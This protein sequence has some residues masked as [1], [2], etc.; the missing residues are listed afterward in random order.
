MDNT[1]VLSAFIGEIG[2]LGSQLNEI[3]KSGKVDI[4]ALEKMNGTIEN[5]ARLQKENS[6][7]EEIAMVSSDLRTVYYNFNAIV[8]MI[9]SKESIFMDDVTMRAINTFLRNINTA[10]VSMAS[11]FNLV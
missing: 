10:V 3:F 5:I 1:S 7:I 11:A 4:T 9:Q 8:S 6:S 2:S